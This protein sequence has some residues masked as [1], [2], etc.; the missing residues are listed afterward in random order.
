MTDN[1]EALG[2]EWLCMYCYIPTVLL[3]VFHC[4][5]IAQIRKRGANDGVDPG[6]RIEARGFDQMEIQTISYNRMESGQTNGDEDTAIAATSWLVRLVINKTG[7][8]RK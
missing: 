7:L 5:T 8:T 3:L 6:R 1:Y 2:V 4:I